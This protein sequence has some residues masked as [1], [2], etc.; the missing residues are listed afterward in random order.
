MPPP[1]PPPYKYKPT[2][3]SIRTASSAPSLIALDVSDRKYPERALIGKSAVPSPSLHAVHESQHDCAS[4]RKTS[5]PSPNRFELQ[6]E[7]VDQSPVIANSSKV[8]G[9]L[10]GSSTQSEF[11]VS[12]CFPVTNEDS[13]QSPPPTEVSFHF[14][15]PPLSPP[16]ILKTFSTSR[17]P[18]WIGSSTLT[19]R[20]ESNSSLTANSSNNN[21]FDTDHE[22]GSE[23]PSLLDLKGIVLSF[24]Y[25][26]TSLQINLIGR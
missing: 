18:L 13:N 17:D 20:S 9:R 8:T 22:G 12:M 19:Q 26:I 2:T 7:S 24:L 15:P 25:H 11:N 4:F 1:V 5:A 6:H 14:S 23:S 10:D 21:N 16:P 3:R